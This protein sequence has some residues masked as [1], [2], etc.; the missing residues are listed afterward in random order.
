MTGIP[1]ARARGTFIEQWP[2]SLASLSIPG[3]AIP[4][5]KQEAIAFGASMLR[6]CNRFEGGQDVRQNAGSVRA[7]IAEA[8]PAASGMMG[9]G[10]VPRLGSRSP[11][12]GI[13]ARRQGLRARSPT[14]AWRILTDGSARMAEDVEEALRHDYAPV[15]H[16]RRWLPIPFWAE[17][18][19]FL[20]RR[21]LLGI[22]QYN[23]LDP[24]V[25]AA[26]A[27][28]A[29]MAE[30]L[31]R[32]FLAQVANA[33]HLESA[34]ADLCL[35]PCDSAASG[36]QVRLIEINPFHP[37]ADWCLFQA[38]D[39]DGS[40]RWGRGFGR[41]EYCLPPVPTLTAPRTPSR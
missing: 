23:C 31:L 3:A 14:E 21:R 36:W 25:E 34:I 5:S 41:E 6:H 20:E 30:A 1:F 32:P 27:P 19:C 13:H 11:K 16:L 8:F 17:F 10:V 29:M 26:L 40:F 9:N 35:V 24:A 18:R 12:D 7:R 15:I 2:K 22:S 39:F 38:G 37:A 4:L 28:H 33:L